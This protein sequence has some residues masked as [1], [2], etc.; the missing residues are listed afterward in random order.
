MCVCVYLCVCVSGQG[1]G[2]TGDT[3]LFCVPSPSRLCLLHAD[4]SD[5]L[6]G[7][8]CFCVF[9]TFE[10]HLINPT[11]YL[12]WF[13]NK[14]AALPV[15]SGNVMRIFFFFFGCRKDWVGVDTGIK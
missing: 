7:T 5:P 2:S 12:V 14:G 15:V 9:V 3:S 1:E 8:P 6:G 11:T 4:T 10:S 13:S